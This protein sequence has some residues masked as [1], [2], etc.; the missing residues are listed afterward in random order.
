MFDASCSLGAALECGLLAILLFCLASLKFCRN[1]VVFDNGVICRWIFCL[2][3]SFL[4]IR[5]YSSYNRIHLFAES[6][7]AFKSQVAIPATVA[8]RS[9]E[10]CWSPPVLASIISIESC[11]RSQHTSHRW[12]NSCRLGG[13]VKSLPKFTC[14]CAFTGN[15][16][17]WVRF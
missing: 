7:A 3:F 17:S 16:N 4:I 1:C 10:N 15:L 8:F 13:N 12:V 6:S 5:R 9:N 2:D 11:I 14:T